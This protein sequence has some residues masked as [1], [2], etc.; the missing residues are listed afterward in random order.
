MREISIMPT[1]DE[2][3]AGSLTKKYDGNMKIDGGKGGLYKKRL[4]RV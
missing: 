1:P 3:P 4:S 2:V